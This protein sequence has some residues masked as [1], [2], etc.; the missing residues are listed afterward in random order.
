MAKKPAKQSGTKSG[1]LPTGI[2]V[3][4][5]CIKQDDTEFYVFGLK[6]SVL[7]PMVS[8][9]RRSEIEDRGYQRVLSQARVEA[10]ANHIKSGHPLPNSVLI[11]LDK[12]SYD[13]RGRTLTIP[14]GKDIGW[15]IDGQHRI[16]GAH[17]AAA[18]DDIE[19]CVELDPGN[20]TGS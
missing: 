16:A 11:A 9:N 14:S 15:V 13:A 19:L 10:V 4:A 7:W 5:L 2:R 12:A 17:E 1:H 20:W 3:P 18:E 6:A 8:I